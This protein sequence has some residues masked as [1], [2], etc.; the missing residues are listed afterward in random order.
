[1]APEND[2]SFVLMSRRDRRL[3]V[4][5]IDESVSAILDVPLAEARMK[6]RNARGLLF[7]GITLEQARS[8]QSVLEH[9]GR[10]GLI[11]PERDVLGVVP[12]RSVRRLQPSGEGVRLQIGVMDNGLHFLPWEEVDLISAGVVG[13]EAFW[14]RTRERVIQDLPDLQGFNDNRLKEELTDA[15]ADR[16]IGPDDVAGDVE[17]EEK[18]VESD[19]IRALLRSETRWLID[20][21]CT[22]LPVR[23]RLER[24]SALFP[25]VDVD[26]REG[27]GSVEAFV[28]V[29]TDCLL[30]AENVVITPRTNSF[31]TDP[32]R[33]EGVFEDADHYDRHVRWFYT[34]VQQGERSSE[35]F[36]PSIDQLFDDGDQ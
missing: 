12:V 16:G 36:L 26:A 2:S 8:L 11:L 32:Y 13:T 30:S 5:R 4:S 9:V 28:H 23:Y 20:L 24:M 7:E 35:E 31:A 18:G 25:D 22:N 27:V 1:M 3:P 34:M 33:L 17:G 15:L 10:E 21:Y 19:Q 29:L 14:S 6:T